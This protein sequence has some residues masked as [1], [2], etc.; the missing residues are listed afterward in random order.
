MKE[1]N[2]I[3]S[4]SVTLMSNRERE[5]EERE[6]EERLLNE[7][8]GRIDDRLTRIQEA[9]DNLKGFIFAATQR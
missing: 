1:T 4:E 7:R 9:I 8:F 3:N 6:L 5:L 2:S